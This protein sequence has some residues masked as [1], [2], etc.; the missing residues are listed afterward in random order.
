MLPTIIKATLK[1]T[2]FVK[3]WVILRISNDIKSLNKK[4]H[5]LK[6][7]VVTTKYRAI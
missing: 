7:I 6:L 5:N 2:T 3:I 4:Q 1:R